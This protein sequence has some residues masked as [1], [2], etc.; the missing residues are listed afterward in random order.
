MEEE[1]GVPGKQMLWSTGRCGGATGGWENAV[2]RCCKTG[3]GEKV[4]G[5]GAT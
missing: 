3:M 4:S 2:G 1:V 5:K